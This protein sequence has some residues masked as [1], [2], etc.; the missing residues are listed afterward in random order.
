LYG[1][2]EWLEKLPPHHGGSEMVSEVGFD[3]TTYLD[4]P[5]KFE[6]GTP[7]FV[8]VIAFG[9][10]IDYLQGIG[11]QAIADYERELLAYAAERMAA[12]D[13][14][15]TFGNAPQKEPVIS[16]DVEGIEVK[17]LETY[18]NDDLNIEVRAGQLSAQP[19]MNF[20]GVSGLVR[21]SF[22]FYNTRDE[23]DFFVDSLDDYI[24]KKG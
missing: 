13:R 10:V 12:L 11:R 17:V 1:R 16:F 20:L 6:A 22:C 2:K 8:D 15:R 5:F 18:F 19:L 23:I 4:V 7:A 24:R 9:T 14:V 3:K 21:A